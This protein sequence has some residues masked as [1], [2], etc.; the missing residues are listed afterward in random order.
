MPES[1]SLR[2]AYAGRSVL[3]TGGSGFLGKVWLGLVMRYL[4]EVER[5]Y[6][7]LRPK[8][9]V[10]AR[11]RFQK[12]LNTSYA[13]EPLHKHFG[14]ELGRYV[15]DRVVPVDG[16]L[17]LPDFGI[18]PEL[19]ARLKRELD[20]VVHC[21]GLVDFNPDVRKAIASNVSGAVNAADFVEACDHAA[22][23]HI[24]TCYVAG[25]RYGRIEEELVENYSP[26]GEGFDAEHELAD[27]RAAIERIVAEYDSPETKLKVRQEVQELIRERRGGKDLPKLLQ[28]FTKRRL[29]ERLKQA[30]TDEGTK[31]AKRW[32]WP[33]TYTYTKSI[34]ESLLAKRRDR[35]R[36]AVLRPT[37]V[38]SA[39][40]FPFPG[41]NESFNGSAPLAYVM[42]T[43]F[44]TVP[45]RPDGPFDVIPVDEVCKGMLIA[46]AAVMRGDHADVYQT[47]TS[48]L[49]P[50]TVGRAAELIAI[51]HRRYYRDRRRPRLEQVVKSRW[52][53]VVTDADTLFG[54][55][56]IRRLLDGVDGAF[57]LLPDKVRE[58]L[59]QL[60]AKTRETRDTM[61][62]LEELC[63]MYLPF[64][65]ENFYIFAGRAMGKHA[66]LEPE[67]RFEP[68]TLDWRSYW[69]DVHMPGLRRWAFPLIEKKR[70]ERYRPAHPVELAPQPR[71]EAPKPRGLVAELGG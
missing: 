15:S 66:V 32:G 54:A 60:Q 14:S 61:L 30:L 27:A 19:A 6:V 12:M 45:A 47:G 37:I 7:L 69:L 3:L 59:G 48:D 50:C 53:A 22:L 51:A 26:V 20:L 49:R 35:I 64:M 56:N 23:L 5:V 71:A 8:A 55:A 4:P 21:G 1:P 65:Y 58:R 52:D 24:S 29:R 44:R 18:E 42:G 38:E 16:D 11:G 13:F 28:S 9:L 41:W 36:L 57:D 70:P 40:S 33:N 62:E 39:R 17:G 68:Q 25:A 43:W 46:G 63:E 10:D 2:R 34:A 67:L 31:R